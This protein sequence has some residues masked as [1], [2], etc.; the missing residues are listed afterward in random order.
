V[1]ISELSEHSGIPVASI[2]FYIREGMLP[3]GTATSATRADYGDEHLAR[4]RVIQALSD[5]RALPLARVKEI[6]SLIDAPDETPYATLGRAVS[7]LPPYADETNT[8]RARE[9][10]ERLGLTYDERFAAVGQLEAAIRGIEAAG[11]TWD[12]ETAAR[13]AGPLL[14]VAAAE[15]LPLA[16]LSESEQVSY[17]VLGT[18]MYE[19]AILALRRLAHQHLLA[20]R[21]T[22]DDM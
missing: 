22:D 5:V 7:A 13:Y 20:T 14:R 4:L 1:R 8:D 16:E 11:L 10:I 2:K 12:A 19:P 3:R 21:A 9:T 17:A 18:A 15:L 6:L